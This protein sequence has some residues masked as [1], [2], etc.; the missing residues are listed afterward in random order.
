MMV[1]YVEVEFL[2]KSIYCGQLTANWQ[3]IWRIA[4]IV[5][6]ERVG[7]YIFIIYANIKEVGNNHANI[8]IFMDLSP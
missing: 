8:N 6:N 4:N 2:E 1:V 5:D 3:W 7:C